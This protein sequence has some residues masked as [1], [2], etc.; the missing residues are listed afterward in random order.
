[1]SIPAAA[2]PPDAGGQQSSTTQSSDERGRVATTVNGDAGLWWVPVGDTNGK[3]MWR[4]SV[5]RNSR[6]TP[7]GHMNVATFTAAVSYG[8]GE[9]A[10]VFASWD[11][12]QRVDRDTRSLFIASDPERGGIDTRLPYARE[13]WTGNKLGDLRVGTKLGLLSEAAGE[14]IS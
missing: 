6:N 9:R 4:G 10:D 2:Q 11:A 13:P 5:A 12:I 1:M 7:Q 3:R 14:S 8:I